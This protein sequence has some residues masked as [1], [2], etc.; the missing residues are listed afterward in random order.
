MHTVQPTS[1]EVE[2]KQLSGFLPSL[3]DGGLVMRSH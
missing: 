3:R 2:G 1:N